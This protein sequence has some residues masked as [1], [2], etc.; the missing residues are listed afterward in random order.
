MLFRLVKRPISG[1]I[2]PESSDL[3][4]SISV[5]FPVE[6]HFTIPGGLKLA[7]QAVLSEDE[8]EVVFP[9]RLYNPTAQQQSEVHNVHEVEPDVEL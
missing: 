1:G 5:T 6:S 9:I 7:Q 2:G 4:Q 8:T 3:D